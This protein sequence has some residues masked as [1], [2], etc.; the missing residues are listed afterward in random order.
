[1]R[2]DEA[3]DVEEP[4]IRAPHYEDQPIVIVVLSITTAIIA[5]WLNVFDNGLNTDVCYQLVSHSL[6]R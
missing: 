1:M 5:M 4:E 6:N 2:R 3:V